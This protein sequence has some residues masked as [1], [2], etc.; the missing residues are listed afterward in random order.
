[1]FE[2]RGIQMLGHIKHG[3]CRPRAILFKVLA[4]AVGLESR[5][6]MVSSKLFCLLR[7]SITPC[8]T[9]DYL[10]TNVFNLMI[11]YLGKEL[12]IKIQICLLSYPIFERFLLLFIRVFQMMGMLNV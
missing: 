3:S 9:L 6:M 4:D 8:H 2:N 10:F 5:L 11:V 1:M 7:I 12:S